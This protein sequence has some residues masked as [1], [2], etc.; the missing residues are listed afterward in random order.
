MSVCSLCNA[1]S[2]NHL[3]DEYNFSSLVS[4]NQS[5]K[6]IFLK[7]AK[8]IEANAILKDAQFMSNIH[9]NDCCKNITICALCFKRFCDYE[10][11]STGL[12]E[13]KA[14]FK[15]EIT[16][17]LKQF[18]TKSF[19]VLSASN[20]MPEATVTTTNKENTGELEDKYERRSSNRKRKRPSRFSLNEDRKTSQDEGE[21]FDP[22]KVTHF[23][24][25]LSS[26]E[27]DDIVSIESGTTYTCEECEKIFYKHTHLESHIRTHCGQKPFVCEICQKGFTRKASMLEHV[28][29]HKGIN[30]F[31]CQ[32]NLIMYLYFCLSVA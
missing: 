22:S 13:L 29:R 20:N 4:S 1:S 14:I 31:K 24:H 28:A 18:D 23:A 9:S 16:D 26:M 3:G 7:I 10:R 11:F 25:E 2:S 8:D 15:K 12:S 17:N 32:A 5:I 6:D 19:F 21:S 27:L 30:C